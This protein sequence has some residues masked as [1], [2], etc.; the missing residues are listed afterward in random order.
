MSDNLIV[1]GSG[2]HEA[3]SD[4]IGSS[5]KT[6]SGTIVASMF[7]MRVIDESL[8]RLRYLW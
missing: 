3:T 5:L 4:T 2:E 6:P 8:V 1:E 7:F